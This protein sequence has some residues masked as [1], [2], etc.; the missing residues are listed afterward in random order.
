MKSTNEIVGV[1]SMY[2]ASIFMDINVS[3]VGFLFFRTHDFS[4][5]VFLICLMI[6]VLDGHSEY[7]E[8]ADASIDVLDI[9]F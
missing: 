3:K 4:D 2:P 7:L 8:F 9:E 6:C 1:V 5:L